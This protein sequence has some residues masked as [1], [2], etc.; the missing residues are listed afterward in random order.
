MTIVNHLLLLSQEPL[1]GHSE[2]ER[3]S[4]DQVSKQSMQVSIVRSLR[5]AQLTT[6]LVEEKKFSYAKE[7]TL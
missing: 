3:F 5:E 4:E 6:V 7:E 1:E 2:I